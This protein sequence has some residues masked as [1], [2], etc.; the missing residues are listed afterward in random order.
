MDSSL[1]VIDCFRLAEPTRYR[2]ANHPKTRIADRMSTRATRADRA[3][4][5]I[6]NRVR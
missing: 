2:R 1:V 4:D 3:D 5:S 6:A